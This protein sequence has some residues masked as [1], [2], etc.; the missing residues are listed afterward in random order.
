MI[1]IE[2]DQESER[3]ELMEFEQVGQMVAIGSDQEFEQRIFSHRECRSKI[4]DLFY[5]SFR[6]K[7][8]QCV[9][10]RFFCF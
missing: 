5:F 7:R 8:E 9:I 1:A 6:M 3:V 4:Q 10:I 2:S